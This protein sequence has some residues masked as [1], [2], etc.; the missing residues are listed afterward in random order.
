M[1]DSAKR[2]AAA[3]NGGISNHDDQET[4]RARLAQIVQD[5]QLLASQ[6]IPTPHTPKVIQTVRLPDALRKKILITGG[7]GFV[8]SHLTDRLMSEDTRWWYSTTFSPGA[9]LMHDVIQ[10]ILLEVDQI[11]HLA[12]P[13]SPPHYQYNP[14]KTIKTSTMGTINMLGLAKRVKHV[15]YWHRQVKSTEIRSPSSTRDILGKCK[16]IGAKIML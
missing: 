9:R 10:P 4:K 1:S 14:V 2:P 3:T 7:A 13:A 8:G 6:S 15:S 12:C 16:H 5:Q 11:Y